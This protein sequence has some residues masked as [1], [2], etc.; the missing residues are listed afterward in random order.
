MGG[1]RICGGY[2]DVQACGH[3]DM[4]E[5]A[6]ICGRADVQACRRVGVRGYAWA[7]P[8]NSVWR[9]SGRAMCA[10]MICVRGHAGVRELKTAENGVSWHTLRQS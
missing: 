6:R 3:V 10:R 8:T 4:R 9:A 2:A 7:P 1:A 5:R